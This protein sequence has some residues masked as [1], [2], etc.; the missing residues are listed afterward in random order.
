MKRIV[1]ERSIEINA[2]ISKVW[3]IIVSPDTWA[4][5]MLVVPESIWAGSSPSNCSPGW[6]SRSFQQGERLAAADH[7]ALAMNWCCHD[8]DHR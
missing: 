7:Q 3:E 2:P 5:W 1:V 8:N 4:R 6:W